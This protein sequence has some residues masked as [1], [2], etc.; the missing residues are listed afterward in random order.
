MLKNFLLSYSNRNCVLRLN[1][2][3]TKK[4]KIYK[5]PI[6]NKYNN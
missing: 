4:K 5:I 2:N 1:H 6:H 3:Q